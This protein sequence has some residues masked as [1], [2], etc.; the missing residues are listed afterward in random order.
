MSFSLDSITSTKQ[1][2]PPRFILHGAE[3]IGKSTFFSNAPEPIF[4]QTETGLANIDAKAFPHARALQD[5]FEQLG[6][7]AES[8]HAFKTVV[9]DSLDWLESLIHKQVCV[10]FDVT[11]I[12][13]AAGGF[14][15][16]YGEA[17]IYWQRII[18]TLEHLQIEKNMNIGL[19]CHSRIVTINDPD[20][21]SYDRWAMKL[22]EPKSNNTGALSLFNEWA[23]II[24]FARR[25]MVVVKKG[26][27]SKQRTMGMDAGNRELCLEGTPAFLAGNRYKDMPAS[28]ELS[29]N[30]FEQAMNN[31]G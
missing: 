28:I 20:F 31:R 25:R 5:V 13:L 10:D 17:L 21:E 27:G 15:K 19:I 29:W 11:T 26:E 6:V 2:L 3:K 7:L 9:I 18:D 4:I 23:D 30:A 12:E 22:H 16:G 1:D 14:G 8:D 24:G